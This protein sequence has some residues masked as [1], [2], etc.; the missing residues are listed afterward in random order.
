MVRKRNNRKNAVTLLLFQTDPPPHEDSSYARAKSPTPPLPHTHSHTPESSSAVSHPL[1]SRRSRSPW[2]LSHFL[3]QHEPH[4]S[5]LCEHRRVRIHALLWE[6]PLMHWLCGWIL[7]TL[8]G[9]G[10]KV[11]AVVSVLK[12]CRAWGR[13]GTKPSSAA[14]EFLFLLV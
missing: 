14:V 10:W 1:P 6:E 11:C 7:S 5:C 9:G 3:F 13:G 2:Y 12:L 8:Y 4:G